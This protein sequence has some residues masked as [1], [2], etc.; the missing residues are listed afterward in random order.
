[1]DAGVFETVDGDPVAAVTG[2]E[3]AE[4]DRVAVEEF[5]L[6]IIQMMEHAG[7]TLSRVVLDSDADRI[8]V[9]AG[10]G[11]NGGGGLACAR[12]LVARDRLHAIVCDR[13]A[14]EYEGA[15][16]TQLHLL[17]A[18][19]L[20]IVDAAATPAAAAAA[21][22]D[23]ELL[24]DALIGYGLS[25]APRG[26]AADLIT[27]MGS[28]ATPVRSL[29]VPSGVDATTGETAGVAVDP[30]ATLTLALPKTG[31]ATGTGRLVCADLGIP[32]GVFEAVGIPYDHPFGD[33]FSVEL[34]AVE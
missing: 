28:A 5:G 3:M 26:V 31:L 12:H 19:G 21:I 1:M 27:E 15:P 18:I 22:S 14:G 32:V 23:S 8:T 16:A 17:E 29:D 9:V 11:G 25:G 13:P 6:G 30:E 34:T 2:T 20:D 24:V 7:R 4:I 33:G 10:G